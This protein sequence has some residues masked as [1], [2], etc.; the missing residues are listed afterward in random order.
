MHL[1]RVINIAYQSYLLVFNISGIL[2]SR[3]IESMGNWYSADCL[4]ITLPSYNNTFYLLRDRF[5]V[6]KNQFLLLHSVIPVGMFLYLMV[7]I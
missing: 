4:S 7:N 6:T 5:R 3:K 1:K 2:S